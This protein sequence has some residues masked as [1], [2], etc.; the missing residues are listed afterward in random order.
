MNLH[1]YDLVKWENAPSK[2]T[3]LSA[4]NLN[5]MD[6]G[7][8]AVYKDV[9]L[10]AEEIEKGGGSG[11]TDASGM[12]VTFDDP[13]KTELQPSGSTLK[14][15]VEGIHGKVKKIEADGVPSD[16]IETWETTE[17]Q[18]AAGHFCA[19]KCGRI[20]WAHGYHYLNDGTQKE[21]KLLT[22]PWAPLSDFNVST[23]ND[24]AGL[25]AS[26]YLDVLATGDILVGTTWSG[27]V[28]YTFTYF[29]ND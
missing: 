16:T 2:A 27:N 18:N 21:T 26:G 17:F 4:E 6:L 10:L 29:T 11:S 14:D 25:N 20:V 7:I 15:I 19:H 28:R 9:E 3:P 8:A 5:H 23:Q 1:T 24:A 13:G 12:T 22:L